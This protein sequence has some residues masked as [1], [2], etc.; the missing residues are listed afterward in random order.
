MKIVPADAT[1][2]ELKKKADLYEE[3][4][5]REP[6]RIATRQ[7]KKSQVVPRV[8]CRSQKWEWK[9]KR[10]AKQELEAISAFVE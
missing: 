7:E 5:K 10:Q 8:D 4:A 6:E 3:E 9:S 2:A 1:I